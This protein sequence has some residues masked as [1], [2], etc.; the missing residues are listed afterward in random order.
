MKTQLYLV[1]TLLLLLNG[2]V[3]SIDPNAKYYNF[4]LVLNAAGVNK[5]E[6]VSH[7]RQNIQNT[8]DLYIKAEN[9]LILGRVT[10]DTTL[11]DVASDYFAK[12]VEFVKDREQKALLYETLASLLGSK[13]YHLRAAIEWKL[14][15]NKFRYQLNKQL[16]MGKMPK[17]KFETS[18]V[19]QNYSLLKENAKELRIGNSDFILTDK[20]KIVSQ[21]DRV[22]RDWLSYQ[23]QEPKSNILLNIFSEGLTYP[24]SE[25]YPEIGWHEGGRVKEIVAKLKLE[26]DVATGTI[27]AKKGGKWY[28][29]NE[30]GVFMFEVPIDKVSYPTLRPFSEN[31]AMIVD[32]HGMN[33]VVSQAIKKNATVVIACC[34]HPGKIKAAKYLSDK[35][36]KVICNTDRFLPLII[37]SGANV[38]GS[39]PFEYENDKILFGDRPVTLHKGQMVVV[40]DYDSTKYALWY[41]DTPKRYFDKLQEVTGVNLNVTVVKLNDFGEMNNVIKVA[42]KEGAKVIGVRVFNRDDYENVKAWLEKNIN[43][44]AILF[45]SEAYPYGYMIAREFA[46]QTSFDDINPVVL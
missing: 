29:P 7:I 23:I 9:Y 12:Q 21:V 35:G 26:R 4:N 30:D 19:K 40:T 45:H 22:T 11:V 46:T 2:C 14:L 31:L 44:K 28:A 25:L 6:F 15:D 20:D 17:L 39:A 18:E 41:Y 10:N 5:E 37:G 16:A 38:L 32:T 36:V 27:V 3:S 13:Y 24:K 33:M 8:N 34:D 1:I 42:E 43:N